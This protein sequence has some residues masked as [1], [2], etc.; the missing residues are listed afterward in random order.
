MAV[1]KIQYRYRAFI[2]YSHADQSLAEGLHRKLETY[3]LPVASR[4]VKP[5]LRLDKRPIR[6]VFRDLDELIPGND[7]S[8]RIRDALVASEYL[9]VVCSPEARQSY[10]V[11]REIAEFISLGRHERILAV[12]VRGEPNASAH[13][14]PSET[15]CFPEALLSSAAE[16]L[17]VDWRNRTADDRKPF[18]RIVA[19]LLSLGSLD[20]L[21]RRDSLHRRRRALLAFGA[22]AVALL[23][24]GAAAFAAVAAQKNRAGTFAAASEAAFQAGDYRRAFAYSLLGLPT[25]D[26]L[27]DFSSLDNAVAAE[28]AAYANEEK[29]RYRIT[30]DVEASVVSP[31]LQRVW[32][33]VDNKIG[34][35]VDLRSARTVA[36]FAWPHYFTP[37]AV[38]ESTGAR[39][40]VPNGD[41]GDLMLLNAADG[42]VLTTLSRPGENIRAFAAA[43]AG[44]II[45]GSA[46]DKIVLWDSITGQ[47]LR[48][49]PR[50]HAISSL[51]FSGDGRLLVGIGEYGNSAV[52]IIDTSTGKDVFGL[53]LPASLA[54]SA[55]LSWTGRFLL[56]FGPP[57]G[58]L[59]DL[60]EKRLILSTPRVEG[61]DTPTTSVFTR[62]DARVCIPSGPYAATAFDTHSGKE[63]VTLK[64]MTPGPRNCLYYAADQQ[65]LTSSANSVWLWDALSG[66]TTEVLPVRGGNLSSTAISGTGASIVTQSGAEISVWDSSARRSSRILAT[67]LEDVYGLALSPDG[68]KVALVRE[69]GVLQILTAASATTLEEF[70]V[71]EDVA[72]SVEFSADGSLIQATTLTKPVVHLWDLV[73]GE[74]HVV[75]DGLYRGLSVSA[76]AF[77]PREN[78]AAL[79]LGDLSVRIVNLTTAQEL[80]LLRGHQ[81]E[82]QS[83]SFSPDGKL[84][85]SVSSE[86]DAFLWDTAG[87]VSPIILTGGIQTVSFSPDGSRVAT[88]C[89]DGNLRIW[90]TRDGKTI[91]QVKARLDLPGEF[92]GQVHFSSD[93]ARIYSE[94]GS[95][96]DGQTLEN[97]ASGESILDMSPN[98]VMLGTSRL[99]ILDSRTNSRLADLLGP[100]LTA[101]RLIFFPDNSRVLGYL[102]DK[103]LRWW[104]TPVVGQRRSLAKSLCS[105]EIAATLRLNASDRED[106]MI[107]SIIGP[108]D[109]YPCDRVGGLTSLWARFRSRSL[110]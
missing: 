31:D 78:V 21:I 1:E 106:P 92:M 47:R 29:L 83:L 11:N 110:F 59:L 26:A 107:H 30:E 55:T 38:F 69:H 56:I 65:M 88:G 2:S 99:G 109:E 32:F 46:S 71:P 13:G 76:I 84:L 97:L 43:P 23:L 67:N 98:G 48:E 58:F 60:N 37:A 5:G 95:V 15:E 108:Y 82:V 10:W 63:I 68:G 17:W 28:K 64:G 51:G 73:Q 85:A 18:L 9:V 19:A 77:S 6:P 14:K 54:T 22:L 89:T 57:G 90:R 81:S 101:H 36:S 40:V 79:A 80:V 24:L 103:S 45:A 53:P 50:N 20:D 104:F 66:R 62:D 34:K 12:V 102:S 4:M 91:G 33:W 35:L 96:W 8:I 93:G 94:F 41:G 25:P 105:A 100:S 75:R 39:L 86:G 52:E 27:F 44:R 72:L 87:S 49:F 7:L 3:V 16:P 61:W 42:R 70:K 74:S